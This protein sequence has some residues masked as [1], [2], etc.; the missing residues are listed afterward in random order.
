MPGMMDTVLNLGL[1]D[2]AVEGL[3]E[4]VDNPRFAWDCYRRF[5]NMFGDVAMGVP[6]H[7]FEEELEKIKREIAKRNGVEDVESLVQ[8]SLNK[9][10]PDT[11]LDVDDLK[12]L[13]TNYKKVYKESVKKDFPQDPMT[14]L[15]HAIDAVFHSWNTERAIAYREINNIRGF[16]GT[17]VNVQ[18]MVFGNMGDDS[19]TGVGFTRSPSTGDNRMYGEFLMNAQ[20]EDVVAGIRTP[21]EIDKMEEIDPKS[22]KELQAINSK[23]DTHYKEMQDFEFTI[24]RGKLYMLQTRRG[25]RTAQAALKVAV[26][27]VEEKL[28]D[29][30]TAIMRIE[31]EQIDQLLHPVFDINEEEKAEVLSKA[32]LPASPGAA[33]GQAVF[34]AKDAEIWRENGKE[35][36][37]CR[38]ETSPDDIRGMNAA[39][40]ILTARGGMTSH[41]AVVARGWGK[42][43]VAGA[44]DII[45]EA[46]KKQMRIG[47]KTIKEGDWI[48]LNGSEGVVYLGEIK[49]IS[50]KMIGSFGIL[51]EWVDEIRKLKVR[52]NSDT[53]KDTSVGVSFGAEGIGLTRTEHMFFEGE[54]I[55]SFHK[56]ILVAQKVKQLRA[57]IAQ[58][59]DENNKKALEQEL[60]QPLKQY[61]Q[62][63]EELLPLQRKDFEGIFK[64]L[65]GYPCTIRLLDPPLHEFL[66]HDEKGQKSL[67]Q[68]MGVDH[69]VIKETVESLHEFNPM[70][71]H[72]GCRLGITYPEITEMQARAVVEAALNVKAENISVHPEIMVPLVGHVKELDLQKQ[73]I[74]DIIEKIKEENKL[75]QLPFKLEIG[76]MIEVPRAA[77]TADEIAK[78]AEFFSF[79][80][81]DLTQMACGFSRDD[82]GKFLGDYINMDIYSVDPFQSL[83]QNGVG[84]LVKTA[85][86]LGK[87]TRPDITLGI[88]GEH[89]GDAESVKFC[90]KVGLDYVSCSPFRVPIARLAAAQVV[91]EE[92]LER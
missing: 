58:E 43:C 38:L 53:P 81:N 68:T 31:P 91:I 32:G 5:I 34:T 40:G 84:K 60:D 64:A 74:L 65:K 73:I 42:C 17:A 3:A 63:L 59:S 79:G 21:L 76:T 52:T 55:T 39:N 29:K 80:T 23:L 69:F 50:P 11:S 51:M 66:P 14:Q 56:M 26:D 54:R 18:T 41:A 35:V 45:V 30:K 67:A 9:V 12:K 2:E 87:K 78:E 6:H 13:V 85:V 10:V 46:D 36:I 47:E 89:G 15:W 70:L 28:I 75:D 62:A 16:M 77:L 72:R 7:R 71:G 48:S 49:T 1:T 4:L 82:A 20:G 88:C 83:D 90:H 8:E 37:L 86:E 92:E 27:M 22:Y 61:L 19:G 57:S 24:E 25:H 44:G 33:M